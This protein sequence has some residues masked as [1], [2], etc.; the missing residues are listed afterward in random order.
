ML[1]PVQSFQSSTESKLA[2]I[3]PAGGVG[4]R[5][6]PLSRRNRPKFLIPLFPDGRSLLQDTYRRI[7]DVAHPDYCYVVT[8]ESHLDSVCE[9]LPMIEPQQLLAEPCPRDSMGAIGIACAVICRRHGEDTVVASFASDQIISPLKNFSDA[10]HLAVN[11][12]KMSEAQGGKLVV[13]GI[14]P[15][16]PATGFGYIRRKEDGNAGDDRNKDNNGYPLC[17]PVSDL[18]YNDCGNGKENSDINSDA[19]NVRNESVHSESARSEIVYQVAEFVEKPDKKQ[20]EEYFSSGKYLWNAGMFFATA[21]FI[22]RKLEQLH[23]QYAKTLK[24]IAEL[25]DLAGEDRKNRE[26]IDLLWHSLPKIAID[27]ALAQPLAAQNQVLVVPA[28]IAWSDIGD[29]RALNEYY[30]HLQQYQQNAYIFQSPDS[31]VI[32]PNKP[33]VII[34]LPGAVVINAEDVILVT[35]NRAAQQVKEIPAQL[36]SLGREELL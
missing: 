26:K 22:M 29:F 9:Q 19:E 14:S 35:T 3:I 21:G 27:Y 6:W 31:I 18:P 7:L 5:L 10:L 23:P 34:D 25:W 32:S 8:G 11:A 12:V 17:I 33:V 24:N 28:N 13:L 30:V 2:V 4:T 36:E 15:T 20:A 16:E 1:A